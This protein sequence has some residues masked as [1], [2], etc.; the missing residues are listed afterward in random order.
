M[1]Y[2]SSTGTTNTRPSPLFPVCAVFITTRTTSST[3]F[4][5]PRF[6][7]RWNGSM[8]L[9]ASTHHSARRTGA[10]PRAVKRRRRERRKLEKARKALKP[11][12]RGLR[13]M[14]PELTAASEKRDDDRSL[15][16]LGEKSVRQARQRVVRI[17]FVLRQRIMRAGCPRVVQIDRP[18]RRCEGR[19]N[20]HQQPQCADLRDRM[21]T[22]PGA[23][24]RSA[25]TDHA[26]RLSKIRADGLSHS[27]ANSGRY[28]RAQRVR[29]AR[30][31][32][33]HCC[34][35]V[36]FRQ[37]C[38]DC[39]TRP[40]HVPADSARRCAKTGGRRALSSHI[41]VGSGR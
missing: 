37:I 6:D 12:N 8:Q 11:Q 3:N 39:R 33:H 2:A 13:V 22:E 40:A 17:D 24:Q 29:R 14:G 31:N 5:V 21:P 9:L 15:Q 16:R 27:C 41:D 18:E 28:P 38:C 20:Q 19:K 10:D 30:T 7:D 23:C 34:R 32:L 1:V 4:M 26:R 35:H 25:T 36:L